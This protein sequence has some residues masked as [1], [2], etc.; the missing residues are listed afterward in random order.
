LSVF[1]IGEMSGLE[2]Y[3]DGDD[4]REISLAEDREE[5]RLERNLAHLTGV[6]RVPHILESLSR[7][8]CRQW[9]SGGAGARN[10]P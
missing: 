7:V 9:S 10:S 1:Q 2:T 5:R 6:H 3:I 4:A 8:S